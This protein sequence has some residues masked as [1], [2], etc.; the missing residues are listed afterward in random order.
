MGKFHLVFL[1]LVFASVDVTA[2]NSQNN[3]QVGLG[4]GAVSPY[5]V[6]NYPESLVA[7][8]E[9]TYRKSIFGLS[10]LATATSSQKIDGTYWFGSQGGYQQTFLEPRV[11]LSVFH[12]GF[13]FGLNLSSGTEGEIQGVASYGPMFGIEVPLGR[14]SLGVDSRYLLTSGSNPASLSTIMMFRFR[15]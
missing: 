11:Y 7:V 14:F 5:P 8:L 2:A 13:A 15:I 10:I 6:S 9:G 4:M 1:V 3:L 12:L